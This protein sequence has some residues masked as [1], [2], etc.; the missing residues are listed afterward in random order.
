MDKRKFLVAGAVG[1]LAAA[2]TSAAQ[3]ASTGSGGGPGLLTV[4]GS[5][6]RGNR[7]SLDPALDQWL[8]K[9]NI[10]FDKA[11]TFDFAMLTRLPAVSF[12]TT[13]Q[14]DAKVH[15]LSGPLLSSVVE[16]AGVSTGASVMLTLQALDGYSVALS[17]ADAKRYRMIV[18]TTLDGKP[19]SIGSLGPLWA[20]YDADRVPE[21]KDKPLQERFPFCP[22]GL[23]FINV[24]SV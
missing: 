12:Q 10:K 13:V 8:V 11:W 4:T 5:I 24:K 22:W 14:Y 19:M 21:F 7:G 16:A 18:A 15:T 1:S 3:A 2:S 6:S 20:V 23:Y 17:L 9:Q